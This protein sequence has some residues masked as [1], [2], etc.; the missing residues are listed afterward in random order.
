LLRGKAKL[1][2]CDKILVCSEGVR[3]LD[4]ASKVVESSF[5]VGATRHQEV[6][7]KRKGKCADRVG[8]GLESRNFLHLLDIPQTHD[9]VS[10][11]SGQGVSDWI[12]SESG[13]GVS[14]RNHLYFDLVGQVLD[15]LLAL[16]L[17]QVLRLYQVVEVTFSQ[18]IRLRQEF[19]LLHLA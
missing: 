6:V 16:H 3:R 4:I 10:S 9:F 8:F 12:E 11:S 1:G 18:R 14:M 13:A 7:V 5:V 17:V 2:G 19:L 15:L